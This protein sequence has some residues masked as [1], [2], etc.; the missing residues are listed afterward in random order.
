M[1]ISRRG[2]VGA[3]AA[4]FAAAGCK[5]VVGNDVPKG[6]DGKVIAGFDERYVGEISPVKWEPFSDKKVR[7]G[8]AGNGVCKFG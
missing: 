1:D 5:S 6:A 4:L 3:G 8:I 2:F 7:V